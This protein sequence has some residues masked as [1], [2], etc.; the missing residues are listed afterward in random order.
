MRVIVRFPVIRRLL[1]IA[2]GACLALASA[3]LH[4]Q[5]GDDPPAQAGP[6]PLFRSGFSSNGRHDDWGQ[7]Y[8]NLPLGPGDRIFTDRDGRAEI[9]LG[10]N[11]LRVGPN[12]DV[13][14][15]DARPESLTFGVAQGAVHVRTLGLWEGQ[16]LY[17]QTPSGSS[18]VNQQADFRVD[19]LP[20]DNAAVFTTYPAM[21]MSLGAGGLGLNT[22]QGQALELIG[23]NPVYPQW[24]QPAYPDALDRWSAGRDQQIARAA[25]YRYV[26]PE[27]PGAYDPRWQRRLGP[28]TE[29]GSMWFPNV[30]PGWAPYHNGHWVNRDPWG[31][32]WVEDESWGYAPF[33]FGRWVSYRGR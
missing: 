29:Y 33:H 21:Y 20:D 4:A 32:V 26:N 19:V 22:K 11:Y 7:A 25:A 17:V 27:I 13:T 30:P 16:S 31:W 23:S 3:P 5:D 24:L 18:T 10:Q 2:I 15:V 6:P 12:S 8:P 1:S 9:Q 14:F 28:D